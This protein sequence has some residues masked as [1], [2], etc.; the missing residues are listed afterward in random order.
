M[1]LHQSSPDATY[2]WQ[3]MCFGELFLYSPSNECLLVWV[4]MSVSVSASVSASVGHELFA[5]L[6]WMYTFQF[7]SLDLMFASWTIYV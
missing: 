7:C 1:I 6:C 3:V 5:Y 4:S 2:C